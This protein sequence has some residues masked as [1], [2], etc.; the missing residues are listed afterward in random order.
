MNLGKHVRRVFKQ[1]S[2]DIVMLYVTPNEFIGI[3]IGRGF[4]RVKDF[5]AK[6]AFSSSDGILVS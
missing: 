4:C 2:T 5:F 1:L 6:N 3:Q